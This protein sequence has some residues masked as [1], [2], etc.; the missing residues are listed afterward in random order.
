MRRENP[1]PKIDE[2]GEIDLNLKAKQ[3]SGPE[4]IRKRFP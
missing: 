4:L 1:R 2:R 3:V